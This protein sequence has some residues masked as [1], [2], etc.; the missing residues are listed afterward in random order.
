MWD[1]P[2]WEFAHSRYFSCRD[3]VGVTEG[4]GLALEI[5]QVPLHGGNS[6]GHRQQGGQREL[7]VLCEALLNC[8]I[9]DCIVSIIV[10]FLTQI[11]FKLPENN[12]CDTFNSNCTNNR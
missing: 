2:L 8:W 9:G 6:R 4:L 11:Q 12:K 7:S 10:F 5:D 3:D 1:S